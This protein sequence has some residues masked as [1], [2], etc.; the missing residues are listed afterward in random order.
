MKRPFLFSF[1]LL[2]ILLPSVPAHAIRFNSQT[3]QRRL[4]EKKA[5]EKLKVL[6]VRNFRVLHEQALLRETEST[7]KRAIESSMGSM[8]RDL[9]FQP[10]GSYD[11]ILVGSGTYE[12]IDRADRMTGGFYHGKKIRIRFDEQQK[13]AAAVRNFRMVFAHELTHLAVASLDGGR[14]PVWL[15][16]G[17]AEY[18]GRGREHYQSGM[19]KA[20]YREVHPRFPDL[21]PAEFFKWGVQVPRIGGLSDEYYAH[22]YAVTGYLIERY[23]FENIRSL[24]KRMK[25]GASFNSAFREVYK[26]TPE[27]IAAAAYGF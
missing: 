26:Q 25:T 1:L 20:F 7:L 22:A 11:V 3:Y 2:L 6:V 5:S 19:A 15:N 12:K 13:G 8:S 21:A 4:Y 27:Q 9:G 10:S 24:L 18:E 16:E 17:L 23:G 14:A